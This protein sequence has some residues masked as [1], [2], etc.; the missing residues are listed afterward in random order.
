MP[1][2]VSE[3]ICSPASGPR[4]PFERTRAEHEP[5]HGRRRRTNSAACISITADAAECR[6]TPDV[7]SSRW[8]WTAEGSVVQLHRPLSGPAATGSNEPVLAFSDG[9][10]LQMVADSNGSISTGVLMTLAGRSA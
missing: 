9:P 7:R 6:H 10:L 2:T 1:T 4:K 5:P 3:S 8:T